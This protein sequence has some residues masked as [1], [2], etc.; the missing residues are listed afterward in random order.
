MR[1]RSRGSLGTWVILA[2]SSLAYGDLR[3]QVMLSDW[4]R[5][6]I[7]VAA[8]DAAGG[9]LAEL[10]GSSFVVRENGHAVRVEDINKAAGPMSICVLI[11]TSGAMENR[12]SDARIAAERF[13]HNLA[14]EDDVC[15]ATFSWSAYLE[16]ELTTDRSTLLDAL[17][18]LKLE[19][20]RRATYDALNALAEIMRKG[21]RWK[22]RAIIVFSAGGDN[23]STMKLA[24]FKDAM[25]AEGTPTVYVVNVPLSAGLRGTRPDDKAGIELA[26]MCGGLSYSPSDRSELEATVDHLNEVLMGRYI[27]TYEAE[28]QARNGRK[29]RVD[30]DLDKEH[31]QAGSV[32][33]TTREYYA[34][35]R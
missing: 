9:A 4:P 3:G 7:E 35:S 24:K 33:G 30:V 18:S 26:A 1:H 19:G 6:R 11:E 15:L 31:Q 16:H 10:T 22:S 8:R 14:V 27:L 20:D 12:I 32:L 21:A 2:A 17:K 23:S 28:D 5:V 29:R 34:P 13:L 25:A